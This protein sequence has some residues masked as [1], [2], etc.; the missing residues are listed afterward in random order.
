MPALFVKSQQDAVKRFFQQNGYIGYDTVRPG[1]SRCCC[2]A[3]PPFRQ[4]VLARILPPPSSPSKHSSPRHTDIID[5]PIFCRQVSKYG[6][7]APRQF[8]A[9]HFPEG[10]ALDST[11][12]APSV[13]D[14]VEACVEEALAA[15]TW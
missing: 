10:I 6:I 2:S 1:L 14:H 13:V 12:V 3:Q 7:P 15:G 5:S 8:L 9:Q 11:Y 4:A